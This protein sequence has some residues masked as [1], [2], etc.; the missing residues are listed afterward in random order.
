MNAV[1]FFLSI[2]TTRGRALNRGANSCRQLN[3]LL[4]VYALCDPVTLTFHLLSFDLILKLLI[5]GR[6]LV[7]DYPC[8]KFGDCTVS[9]VLVFTCG[10]IDRQTE[11]QTPLN[12]L[13]S[14]AWVNRPNHRSFKMCGWVDHMICDTWRVFKVKVTQLINIK[15]VNRHERDYLTGILYTGVYIPYFHCA[16]TINNDDRRKVETM[17][18]GNPSTMKRHVW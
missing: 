15:G 14:S 18:P 7:M 3:R 1:V 2:L 16:W 4:Y 6:G 9:A 13:L 5:G 8:G 17:N 10:Q 12:A 11:S